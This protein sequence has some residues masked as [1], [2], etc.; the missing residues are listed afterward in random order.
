VKRARGGFNNERT[1]VEACKE[2]TSSWENWMGVSLLGRLGQL[3][4]AGRG[5]LNIDRLVLHSM[6]WWKRCTPRKDMFACAFGLGAPCAHS[7]RL[8][9]CI[10]CVQT[11]GIDG[12]LIT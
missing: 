10:I 3:P 9:C 7:F 12:F 5:G 6:Q 4:G 11:C 1:S 2:S 8:R